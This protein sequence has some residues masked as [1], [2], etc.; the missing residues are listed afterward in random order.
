MFLRLV[1]GSCEE[2]PRLVSGKTS[3]WQLVFRKTHRFWEKPSSSLVLVKYVALSAPCSLR[4]FKLLLSRFVVGPSFS[5]GLRE[6]ST[7]L[8]SVC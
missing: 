1:L 4:T 2:N 7:P 8:V 6:I 3:F 5:T